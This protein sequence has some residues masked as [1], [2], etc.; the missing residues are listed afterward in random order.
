[1]ASVDDVA[2][3]ILAKQRPMSTWKLQ[4]LVYYSQAWHLAWDQ[5]RLFDAPIEAWANG[6]VVRAL[7]Q[8]HR[9]QFSVDAWRWG[10]PD[11]LTATERA[12]IDIVL[13]DY[14]RLTGRMLSHLTHQE[15]P[16]RQAREGLEP[17]A[18]SQREISA[19]SMFD[20]YAALDADEDAQSL[21]DW[22]DIDY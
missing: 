7:Y 9:G 18:P 22:E 5:E 11:R 2:A 12:T 15:A 19:E 8:R 17:T 16:W 13:R 21:S 4:K 10:D 6:P 3:Y 20:F 1:M 14:G